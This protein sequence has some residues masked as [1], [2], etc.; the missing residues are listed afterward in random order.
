MLIPPDHSPDHC[1]AAQTPQPVAVPHWVTDDLIR[2]TLEIWNPR[3]GFTLTR[4]DAIAMIL[5]VSRLY[6]VLKNAGA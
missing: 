3:Y 5:N 6:G 2:R 4:D 1:D